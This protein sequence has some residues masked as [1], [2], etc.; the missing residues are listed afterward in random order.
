MCHM[1]SQM[2]NQSTRFHACPYDHPGYSPWSSEGVTCKEE[3]EVP[4]EC[5]H[6]WLYLYWET[7]DRGAKVYR[8]ICC[9]CLCAKDDHITEK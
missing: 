9:K 3:I 8:Y 5:K 4:E 7:R 2:T 1:T 6:D